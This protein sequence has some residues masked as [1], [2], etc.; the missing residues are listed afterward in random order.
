M[1]KLIPVFCI[2]LMSLLTSAQDVRT[3]ASQDS[4]NVYHSYANY[5]D[6]VMLFFKGDTSLNLLH[7]Y[8][9]ADR[10]GIF[11]QQTATNG[12]QMKS[13]LINDF[14]F[15]S[16]DF[17][18]NAYEDF[19][20]IPGKFAYYF[21]KKPFTS[22]HYVMGGKREQFFE[23]LHS[24]NIQ[25]FQFGAFYRILNHPGAYFRDKADHAQTYIY[26]NYTE[27]NNRL[28]LGGTYYLNRFTA[29]ENGGLL[30]QSF[31]TDSLKID[32]TLLPVKLTTAD[33]KLRIRGGV[34]QSDFALQKSPDSS[35]FNAGR[36][37]YSLHYQQTGF[38]FTDPGPLSLYYPLPR[39]SLLETNDSS[40]YSLAEH[41]FGWSNFRNEAQILSLLL[42]NTFQRIN[43]YQTDTSLKYTQYIPEA[44]LRLKISSNIIIQSG[45]KLVSGDLNPGDFFFNSGIYW[46]ANK[47]LFETGIKLSS[48]HAPF[49]M[50][51]FDSNHYHWQ[52]QFSK[53]VRQS[54]NFAYSTK[55]MA[56]R[57]EYTNIVNPFFFN[58]LSL[59]Q[60]YA[61]AV[62]TLALQCEL[63][64]TYRMFSMT[65]QFVYQ[66]SSNRNIINL[67]EFMGAGSYWINLQLFNK[68]LL[69]QTGI[70]LRYYSSWYA[71]AYNPVTAQYRKQR[72]TETGAYL[73]ADVFINVKINQARLF[74]KYQHFNAGL[75]GYDYYLSPDIP[76]QDASFRFGLTWL[77]FN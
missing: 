43:I 5:S 26:L 58:A 35:I 8:S 72:I 73:F 54:V 66:L 29:N 20:V 53:E 48:R 9:M 77:F 61:G 46:Q 45:F 57:L 76:M 27:K 7:R 75:S 24:Q 16:F 1:M 44:A 14:R 49:L 6:S 71:D 37:F 41:S 63:P 15:K 67:P 21:N 68:A 74:V 12:K 10:A 23:V 32:R 69:A 38:S 28:R 17:G 40:G 59:P 55:S 34:I 25:Q 19:L 65:N 51:R 18:L 52:S 47:N 4:S 60:Q 42:K 50:R 56:F 31:F 70:D 22:A 30:R 11:M 2:L 64:Y 33:S 3:I 36:I 39:Y 62:P 13:L